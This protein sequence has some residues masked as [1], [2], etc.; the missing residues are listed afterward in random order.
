[1]ERYDR[2]TLLHRQLQ[3][4]VRPLTVMQ[5]QK[6]SGCSRATVYR[7]LAFLRDVLMAPVEGDGQTGFCYSQDDSARFELP[8]IW[9]SSTELHALMTSR[10][11]FARA[12]NGI[13]AS[14]LAPFQQRIEGILTAQTAAQTSPLDRIRVILHKGRNVDETT[15]RTVASAVLERRQ[16]TF[17][18]RARTTDAVTR[19]RVSPQ[20][21]IHYRDNW[22]LDGWDHT[23]DAIRSFAIDRVLSARRENANARDLSD[24]DLDAELASSYGIFAG[25][26]RGWATI[27][28]SANAA[29]WVADETWHAKQQGH[30][31]PD[32]RY[33]LRL[34]YSRTR[35][36]LMDVLQYGA[37]ARI[38]EPIALREQAK[39]LLQ[40]ALSHY[41]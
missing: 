34:P 28:F 27:I 15:F 22:Y 19:R 7:D 40:L 10:Q 1:M 24:H 26:P 12:H 31:L 13:F 21:V 6:Q 25:E 38:I 17:E 18:Y 35:E 32:G 39:A 4:A 36:L 20:R 16:I 29:R 2:I 37:D 11:L 5:L 9:L 33:R 14:M 41:E 23:R 30:F 3:T 8:G